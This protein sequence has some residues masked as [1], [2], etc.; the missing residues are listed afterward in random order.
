MRYDN[1]EIG[2]FFS[3]VRAGLWEESTLTLNATN[4][5]FEGVDWGEVYRLAEEQS[6]LGLVS[7]GL[8]WFKVNDSWFMVPQAVALQFIGQT[9]QI[10]Q[11]N[12]AMNEFVSSLIGL[13][14]E[15]DVYAIL[16]KGQGVHSAMNAPY[17]DPV[18]M[19]ICC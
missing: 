12:K 13:L 6:V 17:G 3:L 7:A 19:W 1:R 15:N 4:N 16:V 14:R 11:R 9:L 5:L 10:E 8:D 2:T 18:G